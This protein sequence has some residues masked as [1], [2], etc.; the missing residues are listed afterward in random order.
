MT[1]EDTYKFDANDYPIPEV[2]ST[3]PLKGEKDTSAPIKDKSPHDE[4]A[5]NMSII[6]QVPSNKAMFI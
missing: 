4:D 5:F 3:L 2:F 6:A 1:G